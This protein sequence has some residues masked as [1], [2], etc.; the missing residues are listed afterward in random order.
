[1]AQTTALMTAE[2]LLLLPDKGEKRFE[3]VVGVL[4]M[5]SPAGGRHG[6][7][8][9][10]LHLLLG[11]YVKQH[12]LGRTFIGDTGFLIRRNPDTVRAPDVSFVSEARLG[13][14]ANYPGFLPL[15]PDLVAEVVSPSDRPADV[16]D[17]VAD[18]LL[19]GVHCVL[20]I[21]PEKNSV[22]VHWSA[23]QIRD[24]RDGTVDLTDILPGFELEVAEL[25]K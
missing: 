7:I 8:A 3:L 21:Y 11:G 5:M 9:A 22:S 2:Q 18:W 13:H 12:Q 10:N 20:V 19:A 1:M 4:R 6:E 23:N 14:Y 25:F 16:N 24:Y 17:K 15:A